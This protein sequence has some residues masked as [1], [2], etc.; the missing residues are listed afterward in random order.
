VITRLSYVLFFLSE[1]CGAT[2]P[3]NR[4][5]ILNKWKT[6]LHEGGTYI[7]PNQWLGNK[8]GLAKKETTDKTTGARQ[9]GE[10]ATKQQSN[11]TRKATEH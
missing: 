2:P 9:R 5:N 4:R 7:Q 6:K 8:R 1:N 10:G 11:T 3:G